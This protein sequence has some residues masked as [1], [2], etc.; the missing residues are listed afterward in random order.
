[1][2][3]VGGWLVDGVDGVQ[4]CGVDGGGLVGHEAE[5]PGGGDERR[6]RGGTLC[7]MAGKPGEG[8]GEG[9]G[10]RVRVRVRARARVRVRVRVRARAR[11][12]A[13]VRARVRGEG[14]GRWASVGRRGEGECGRACL[15]CQAWPV[16]PSACRSAPQSDVLC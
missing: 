2:R 3:W 1:M 16:V 15:A 12:R 13:R 10:G 4:N 9:E 14:E 5:L 7:E 11:A 8:E 6:P